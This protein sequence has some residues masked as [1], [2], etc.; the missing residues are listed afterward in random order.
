VWLTA[1]N[2]EAEGVFEVEV[3]RAML[4]QALAEAQ[5]R[6]AHAIAALHLRLY[7]PSPGTEQ[8]L[9][10]LVSRLCVHTPAEGAQVFVY[11]APSR[12]VC[13]NCCG[14]CFESAEPTATCP[15]CGEEGLL[16]P[17]DVV[18]ALERVEVAQTVIRQT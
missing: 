11:Q 1:R 12:F 15:N 5:A 2:L 17:P 3:V 8:E 14:L 6:N 10:D 9:R 4:S 18:F 16:I 7:D 13:W